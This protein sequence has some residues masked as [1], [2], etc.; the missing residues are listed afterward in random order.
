M[1]L[2]L[3]TQS[4]ETLRRCL[5]QIN[6]FRNFVVLRFTPDELLAILANVSLLLQE[7]QVWCKFPMY[8]IFS[9]VEVVSQCDSCH[10]FHPRKE[11][12]PAFRQQAAASGG[13]P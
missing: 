8:A 13:R 6:T 12:H 9:E 3:K 4:R 10:G 5:A 2:K 11:D 7:P 1:K